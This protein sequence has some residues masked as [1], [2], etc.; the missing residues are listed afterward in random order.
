MLLAPHG[1]F[2]K[3][4]EIV[5]GK[6]KASDPFET[7]RFF[8]FPTAPQLLHLVLSLYATAELLGMLF[9]RVRRWDDE[10]YR[11]RP[12]EVHFPDPGNAKQFDYVYDLPDVV[13]PRQGFY[14][15]DIFFDRAVLYT[16]PLAIVQIK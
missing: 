13:F 11:S 7:L 14:H 4:I 5:D 10:I 8:E 12:I 1:A 9:H 6:I 15:I 2:Y 16:A 3:N